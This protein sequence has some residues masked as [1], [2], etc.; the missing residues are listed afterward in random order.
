[1]R[2]VLASEHFAECSQARS[3]RNRIG[4]VGAAVKDLVLRDQVHHGL[5][6]AKRRQR[7][8]AADRF[9]QANHVRLHAEIFGSAAP[10]QFRAGLHFVEDQ[11][12]AILGGNVAQSL[13][14]AGLRHAQADVHQDRLENDG[15]NLA[16]ILLEAQFDAGQ[17]VEGR[18]QHVGDDAFGTP[19]PPGTE[20]GALMSP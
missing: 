1:M 2:I 4:V 9:R 5:V 6:R 16:G 10:A 7:Q 11:Q 17:I 15:R 3:H 19:S 14:K 8:A 12:R 13:Q 20:V 18:N